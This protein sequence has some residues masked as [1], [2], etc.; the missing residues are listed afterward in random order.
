MCQIEHLLIV[1]E[2]PHVSAHLVLFVNHAEAQAVK[3]GT[4]LFSKTGQKLGQIYFR[5]P[6]LFVEHWAAT[7]DEF[8][9]ELTVPSGA[10]HA[11][12]KNRDRFN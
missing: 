12:L 10:I 9:T 11:E 7:A 2:K 5:P 3:T 8:R 6:S 4:D 1:H